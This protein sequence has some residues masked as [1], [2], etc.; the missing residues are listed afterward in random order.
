V[1][2]SPLKGAEGIGAS[3]GPVGDTRKRIDLPHVF[4]SQK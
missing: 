3:H 2:F 1:D 4:T